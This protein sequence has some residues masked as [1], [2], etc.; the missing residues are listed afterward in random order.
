MV[1]TDVQAV[2][3]RAGGGPLT[4]VDRDSLLVSFKAVPGHPCAF[5]VLNLF[6]FG[7]C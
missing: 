2:V 1:S 5:I 7:S 4:V 6:K 3:R